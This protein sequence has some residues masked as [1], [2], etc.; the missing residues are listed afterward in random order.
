MYGIINHRVKREKEN[1][2]RLSNMKH[3]SSE[4]F[5]NVIGKLDVTLDVQGKHPFKT[6]F[7]LRRG[8]VVGYQDFD[9][10]YYLYE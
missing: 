5:Y 6:V 3:V 9:G 7:K 4:E 2:R 8:N 1:K 10:K